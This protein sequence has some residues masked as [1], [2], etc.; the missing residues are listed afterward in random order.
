MYTYAFES[1]TVGNAI[2]NESSFSKN[3]INVIKILLAVPEVIPKRS[4]NITMLGFRLSR[5]RVSIS[6]SRAGAKFSRIIFVLQKKSKY[7]MTCIAKF[8]NKGTAEN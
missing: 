2:K 1:D 8:Y 3:R 4:A 6:C 7:L 5:T